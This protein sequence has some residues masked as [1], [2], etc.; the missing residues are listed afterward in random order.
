MTKQERAYQRE[1]EQAS[2][3]PLQIYTEHLVQVLRKNN[4][5]QLTIEPMIVLHAGCAVELTGVTYEENS[6]KLL[7]TGV[8]DVSVPAIECVLDYQRLY[9]RTIAAGEKLAYRDTNG[10]VL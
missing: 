1:I 3:R 4:V 10:Y 5:K 9:A 8:K 6:V 2:L 7:L